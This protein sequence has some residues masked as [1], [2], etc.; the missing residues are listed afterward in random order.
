MREWCGETSVAATRGPFRESVRLRRSDSL[1]T[2]SRRPL[3][4]IFTESTPWFSPFKCN[5]VTLPAGDVING[6]ETV[7]NGMACKQVKHDTTAKT[8]TDPT[9][10]SPWFPAKTQPSVAA[11]STPP[12]TESKKEDVATQSTDN[13]QCL[14]LKRMGPAGQITSHMY[15]F[16]IRGKQFQYFE[17][18]FPAGTIFHGRLTDHDIRDI[19]GH[20]GK[21]VIMEPKYSADDL[22][23][24]KQSCRQQ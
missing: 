5:V 8:T 17:G 7:V 24:A 22:R 10:F 12:A 19:Q 13:R 20:N 1:A 11:K 9:A 21:V 18:E 2:I 15:S 16:G 6:D 3:L 4:G 23:E 14:I